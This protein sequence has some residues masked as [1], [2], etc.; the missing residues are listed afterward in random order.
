MIV[1]PALLA[2]A[3]VCALAG[4]W[5]LTRS[6]AYIEGIPTR[7][8]RGCVLTVIAPEGHEPFPA[9]DLEPAIAEWLEGRPLALDHGTRIVVTK[10]GR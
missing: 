1:V 4:A 9:E 2:L 7:I 8:P 10:V 3:A 6:P 5:L